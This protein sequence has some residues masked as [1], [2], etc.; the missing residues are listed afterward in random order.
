MCLWNATEEER[1]GGRRY[2]L[3]K[4]NL[5]LSCIDFIILFP[6]LHIS[7]TCV[8]MKNFM[9]KLEFNQ[10]ANFN[11]KGLCVFVLKNE[12]KKSGHQHLQF[13]HCFRFVALF[14][15]RLLPRVRKFR[16]AT[17]AFQIFHDPESRH[18]AYSAW[19]AVRSLGNAVGC[20]DDIDL[21]PMLQ[22]HPGYCKIYLQKISRVM[23]LCSA[24]WRQMTYPLF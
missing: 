9:S 3:K 22:S 7:F 21:L 2:R 1:R 13:H 4:S 10:V 18:R 24:R 14:E 15:S 19:W 20:L 6:I 8:G 17:V 16:V 11:T 5:H 12:I 23:N